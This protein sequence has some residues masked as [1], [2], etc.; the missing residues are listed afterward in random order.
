[1]SG[2]SG[3]SNP[4]RS[5]GEGDS[6][7]WFW[8]YPRASFSSNSNAL[9]HSVSMFLRI[10]ISLYALI[11]AIPAGNAKADDFIIPPASIN[12]IDAIAWKTI[13]EKN[14]AGVVVFAGHRGNL[15]FRKAYGNSSLEPV[16][17]PMTEDTIFDMASLTKVVATTT[18]VLQLLEN[19][20]LSL[21]DPVAKYL[22][23]FR[24]PPRNRITVRQCLTHYS[25]LPPD[26][27]NH[28]LKYTNKSKPSSRTIWNKIWQI[29][30]EAAPDE[31]WIYSDIGFVVLGRLVEKVTGKS[32]DQYTREA[33]FM[34]L[35][36]NSTRYRP[37]A[38]WRSHIAA[39]EKKPWGEVLL[40]KVHDPTAYLLGGVAGHAG[41]F[42]KADDLVRFCQMILNGGELE[43]IR[44]LKPETVQLMTSP[45]S[46]PGKKD[47]RGLGWDIQTPHSSARG[48]FFSPQSF[49]HTGYTGTSI[50][51]DPPSQT[52]VIIL[53]NRVHPHDKGSS[54][55]LRA[56]VANVV[57]AAVKNDFAPDLGSQQN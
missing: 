49:G 26:L 28:D 51:I 6:N 17:R 19:G 42:S 55:Y 14:A 11:L 1:M 57:G 35:K 9:Y 5:H 18:A 56:E 54:K 45:Q 31:K 38:Q 24:T 12:E 30:P 53:S 52:Y 34:P 39:T 27:P 41:L 16:A 15:F 50:W 7:V 29:K 44:I 40:G 25:G 3:E 10:L 33:I 47:I 2:F 22:P 4:S 43:G 32:L 46:P 13:S 37:P 36:M 20:K 8:I 48:D 23:Q 21:E